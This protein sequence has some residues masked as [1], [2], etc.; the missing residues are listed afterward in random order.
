MQVSACSSSIIS[1]C[2]RIICDLSSKSSH[3]FMQGCTTR[4][5]AC[6]L[7]CAS[8]A[9]TPSRTGKLYL[10]YWSKSKSTNTDRSLRATSR[11]DKL[12][13]LYWLLYWYNRTNADAVCG[14]HH[15]QNARSRRASAYR[16][17]GLVSMCVCACVCVCMYAYMY[18]RMYV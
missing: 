6:L 12:Y 9:S 11:T 18:V 1:E 15:A 17:R 10:L 14:Q 2:S 5:A 8:L 3:T 7:L 4:L 13:L 16:A